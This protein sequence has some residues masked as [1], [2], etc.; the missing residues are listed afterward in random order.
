MLL[1]LISDIHGD[2]VA[3]E[4]AWDLLAELGAARVLCA[5]DVVGY[6]PDPE[7]VVAFLQAHGILTASG[8][9]DLW[10]AQREPG[11][12]DRF[13]GA[14]VSESTRAY[15]DDLPPCLMLSLGGR[16]VVV[17]HV[18]PGDNRRHGPPP[19]EAIRAYRELTGAELLVAGHTHAPGWYSLG[20]GIAV[21]PGSLVDPAV[22]RSSRSFA[23]VDLTTLEPAFYDLDSGR[24]AIVEPWRDGPSSAPNC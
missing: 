6:G 3:L 10:A 8:N 24:P 9:H 19:L 23:T 16:F 11:R 15:L 13:G 20:G 14:A 1:G 2:L 4:R 12:G 21:N 22:V 18:V 7:G 17:R 5:G